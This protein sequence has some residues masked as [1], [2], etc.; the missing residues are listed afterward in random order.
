MRFQNACSLSIPLRSLLE[1]L[2]AISF[3][4]KFLSLDPVHF[5]HRTSNTMVCMYELSSVRLFYGVELRVCDVRVVGH[6]SL[7]L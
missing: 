5:I 6:V 2:A 7:A 3:P 4:Y 1:S